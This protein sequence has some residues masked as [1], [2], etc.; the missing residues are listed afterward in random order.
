[1]SDADTTP[2]EEP[3]Q[4]TPQEKKPKPQNDFGCHEG[5][6]RGLGTSED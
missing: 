2:R 1:M 3:P 6:A 4:E 5:L